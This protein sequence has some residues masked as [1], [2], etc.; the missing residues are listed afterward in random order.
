MA[1]I[2]AYVT[3]AALCF[4]TA[5]AQVFYR[6]SCPPTPII[7]DFDWQRYL[8]KWYEQEKYPVAYQAVGRC[9]TGT[10]IKD[11]YSGEISVRLDF[12]DIVLNR[13]RIL[14]VDIG[15]KK[16]YAE[17]NRLFYTLP[18]VPLFEDEY[19]IL[20]TDY[21]NWTL[22]YDCQNQPIGHTKIA[23]ILTRSPR[24]TYEVIHEAKTTLARLGIDTGRLERSDTSC[25][26]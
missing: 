6:G 11:K 3:V 19:E 16:P 13:P 1:M 25:F 15:R 9:W 22:E 2:S 18:N 14:T 24:P 23:W 4:A 12:K 10:Y 21:D 5:Q 7:K 26:T 17:P 8:G 20:A